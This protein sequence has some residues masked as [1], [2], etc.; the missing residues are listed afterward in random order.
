MV[1]LEHLID[2]PMLR[3][4]GEQTVVP[5]GRSIVSLAETIKGFGN[6]LG[7]LEQS[8]GFSYLS[9]TQ[10]ITVPVAAGAYADETIGIVDIAAQ[11]DGETLVISNATKN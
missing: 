11:L 1:N 2:L 4:F 5:L 7:E 8:Y 6:R 9:E 10:T 3:L